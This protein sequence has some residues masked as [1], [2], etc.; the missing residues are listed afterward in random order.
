M[1]RQSI[2]FLRKGR[3]VE[4]EN[5]PAM[6]TVLDYLRL[7]EMSKG[8][9]EGCNEGDC[10]ACTVALGTLVDGKVVYEPVNACIMLLG[11]LEGKEL[12][13]IDDLAQEG[14]LHPLQ[15]AFVDS[16]AS[17]CGFCTPGFIMALFTLYHSGVKPTR[18]EI[19]DHVAG[20]LCRCTG[21]RPIVD[22]ATQACTGAIADSWANDAS[23]DFLAELQDEN[24]IQ[25]GDENAFFA[26]PATSD[27]L[28]AL[29]AA[30]PNATIVAGATD[31]GLWITKQ[32]RLLPKIISV[33]RARG[34]DTIEDVPDHISIGAGATY[35]DAAPFL[36]NIDPDIGEVIRRIGAKQV[37]ASGT[38][39]GNI[40]N[41]SPI[42]DMPPMLIALGSTL[43]LRHGNG[44]RS[45]P[46]ENFFLA[47]GKQ[48]RRP[49]ELVWRIDVPKL[50][51]YEKFRSYKLSKRRDQD[52]SAV[53][54][55]F[56]FNLEGRKIV[57]ARIT[58]GGMAATPKRAVKT[59]AA[60]RLASLDE[61]L[62]WD[63]ALTALQDDYQP[64]ADMRASAEYRMDMAKALLSRALIEISAGQ[65]HPLRLAGAREQAV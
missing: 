14:E 41:G 45:M 52:I 47:Y 7:T 60:L 8:T 42:G 58:F 59:E 10:G 54:A 13:T 31:V 5:V 49:G 55:S 57:S 1:P 40:A 12:I 9:K 4:L 28:A 53:M 22:A 39:G 27:A 24:D 37:R 20:N 32:L 50:K 30:H 65:T 38:I 19:V 51:P 64:V 11:Q 44:L 34:F 56:K 6:R 3:I 23:A 15:R 62:T 18:Q 29:Y 17:Q 25:I 43:H 46:L 36:E 2:R 48:D 35:A 63:A 61:P 26:A 16:H 21:Y 33:G